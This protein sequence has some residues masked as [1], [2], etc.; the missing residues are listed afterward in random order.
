MVQ[1]KAEWWGFVAT[2]KNLLVPA[3][4]TYPTADYVQISRQEA[5][6]VSLSTGSTKP[7]QKVSRLVGWLVGWLV[8]Y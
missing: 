3:T 1:D 5:C 2:A 4:G 8:D 6:C 7:S